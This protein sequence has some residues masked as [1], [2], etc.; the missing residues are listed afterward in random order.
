[1]KKKQ[2]EFISALAVFFWGIWILNPFLDTFTLGPM[3]KYFTSTAS[4][5]LWGGIVAL[6]GLTQLTFIFTSRMKIR[7]VMSFINMLVLITLGVFYAV[8][9]IAS[10]FVPVFLVLALCSWFAF[11]EV[12][13]ESHCKGCFTILYTGGKGV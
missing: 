2:L 5:E 6:I 9:N 7:V 10:A 4:E 8:G 13:T 3:Y 1:M 11:I 12:V